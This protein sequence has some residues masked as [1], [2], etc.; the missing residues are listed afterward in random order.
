MNPDFSHV[1]WTGLKGVP[2]LLLYIVYCCILMLHLS[3]LIPV[4]CSTKLIF[5]KM[6]FTDFCYS[7]VLCQVREH[8]IELLYNSDGIWFMEGSFD[9][10]THIDLV[11]NGRTIDNLVKE[12]SLDDIIRLVA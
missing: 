1:A 7:L 5:Y 9:K 6:D 12:F 8:R 3:F 2:L 4:S 11:A 10:I